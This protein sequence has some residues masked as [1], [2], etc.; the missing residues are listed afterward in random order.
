[1]NERKTTAKLEAEDDKG[2]VEQ[3]ENEFKKEKA[4]F[5]PNEILEPLG[6]VERELTEDQSNLLAFFQLPLYEKPQKVDLDASVTA[7]FDADGTYLLVFDFEVTVLIDICD[8]H[9]GS[10][11]VIVDYENRSRFSLIFKSVTTFLSQA[12]KLYVATQALLERKK[13]QPN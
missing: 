1:M 8:V 2:V 10:Y 3:A 11:D 13:S 4:T 7:G 6:F 12:A 5:T 9:I